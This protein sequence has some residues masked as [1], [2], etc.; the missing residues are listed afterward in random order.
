MTEQNEEILEHV[1]P[2]ELIPESEAG[3]IELSPEEQE[4]DEYE[5]SAQ[6]FHFLS[7]QFRKMGYALANRKKRAAI[8][9]LEAALFR[10]LE[11]VKLMG[12]EEEELYQVAMQ[13]MY[14]KNKIAEYSLKRQMEQEAKVKED[15]ENSE[16]ENANE[17]EEV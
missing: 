3:A 9:V 12:K 1:E 4:L 17:S 13:I 11:D 14:H 16:K 2:G 8:R 7:M 6:A 5:Q 10:P 15:L